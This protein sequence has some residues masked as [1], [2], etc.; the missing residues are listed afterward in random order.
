MISQFLSEAVGYD[1]FP[2]CCCADLETVVVADLFALG[3]DGG[4]VGYEGEFFGDEMGFPALF[5]EAGDGDVGIGSL[6]GEEVVCE[7]ED[8]GGGQELEGCGEGEE[9]LI[10]GGGGEDVHIAVGSPLSGFASSSERSGWTG[11]RR[12]N[13]VSL[14]IAYLP[15][16]LSPVEVANGEQGSSSAAMAPPHVTVS[17]RLARSS[18]RRSSWYVSATRSAS[19]HVVS[20]LSQPVSEKGQHK[21]MGLRSI[22][23]HSSSTCECHTETL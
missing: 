19:P 22:N 12:E 14:C 6:L 7:S 2:A 3:E 9:V 21:E 5:G 16:I 20:A 1:D 17:P 8:E 10:L 18:T 23:S 13:G 11:R 4:G 15:S